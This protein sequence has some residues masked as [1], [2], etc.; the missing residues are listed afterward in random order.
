[1]AECPLLHTRRAISHYHRT[2]PRPDPSEVRLAA[3][4]APW[5]GRA[6]GAKAATI[7][8]NIQLLQRCANVCDNTDSCTLFVYAKSGS[9]KGECWAEH[10]SDSSCPE[11]FSRTIVGM[12]TALRLR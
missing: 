4:S 8:W 1:M 5:C 2:P 11:G 10:A 12:R 6:R 7:K 3:A 9:R